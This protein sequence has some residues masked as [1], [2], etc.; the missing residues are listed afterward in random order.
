MMSGAQDIRARGF[1]TAFLGYDRRQVDAFRDELAAVVDELALRVSEL[2]QQLR[3]FER[4]K[5]ITAD[6]AF[7]NVARETQRIL[8]AAQDAGARM[9]QQARE[10][11]E[12]ELALARREHA[13]IVGDGYR[14]RDKLANH[15]TELDQARARLLRQ[16]YD[17][18]SEV[19]RVC[20][21]LE[22][23]ASAAT[24]ARRVAADELM[25]HS[26]TGT[27][28]SHRP[29]RSEPTLRVVAD[30]AVDESHA[31]T[32]PSRTQPSR[33][34]PPRP[35][36]GR[37][38]DP[39]G[40]KQAQLAQLRTTLVEQLR[41]ELRGVSDRLRER[42]RQASDQVAAVG[43]IA[44]DRAALAAPVGLTD[45]VA[46]RAFVLGA[47]A[48]AAEREDLEPATRDDD[49][50]GGLAAVFDN[51]IGAGVRTVLEQA[52][53]AQDPPWAVAERVDGVIAD[54][55][56]A[57]VAE[58]AE[59]ELS[60]A[61]ERGKLATWSKGSVA[62][63]RWVLNPHGHRRDERCRQNQQAGAVAVAEVFPSGD[64]VPPRVS[65]CTC[66]TSARQESDP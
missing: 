60:R 63:R 20:V 25:E 34:Q 64:L 45:S 10:R 66:T 47:R 49:R 3:E 53:Q 52:A 11:A 44:F 12:N 50:N 16:L 29:L 58:I 26:R 48:A 7:A 30:N 5:P 13:Q 51:S 28:L 33:T 18:S 56:E 65:G 27:D 36:A 39:T 23:E 41:E 19:E 22:S 9:L 46:G 1:S 38:S 59:M 14:T 17:A 54:A 55:S 40:D 42:L 57:M 35:G 62:A 2:E 37:G 43:E 8:Q 24:T 4:A 31:R 15:L 32:Q 21:A 6:Q 61:Y